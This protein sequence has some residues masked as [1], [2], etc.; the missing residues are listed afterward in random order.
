MIDSVI[1]G[2]MPMP[3]SD[4]Y[5]RLVTLRREGEDFAVVFY[6]QD[7]I[8]FRNKDVE[9]LRGRCVPSCAG[10]SLRTVPMTQHRINFFSPE[11]RTL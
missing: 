5:R 8:A 4:D 6:P 7:I 1:R 11:F 2:R 9:K 3:D 10:R